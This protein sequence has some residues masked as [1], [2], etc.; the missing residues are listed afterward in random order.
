M[1]T[2]PFR[3]V[4]ILALG[5]LIATGVTIAASAITTILTP[6]AADR[7]DQFLDGLISEDE[8]LD[9][10]GAIS[11][12]QLVQSVATAAT[13]VM[14]IIW[15]YRVA[16]NV[17]SVGRETTWAPIFA[18]FGWVLPPVLVIIPFLMLRE[19]WKA[20]S[21]LPETGPNDWRRTPDLPVI[22]I[23]FLLYGVLQTVLLVVQASAFVGGSLSNDA[24]SLAES[25]ENAGTVSIVSGAGVF[26]AGVAWM[27][28]VRR[29]T[30]RHME[31]TNEA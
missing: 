18:I 4:R 26:L 7:A 19:L 5:V 29:L 16:K 31:L 3:R 15:M 17:R 24:E 1:A 10:Y 21:P 8:F 14:T 2:E 6:A 28:V 22:W 23:W 9:S 27:I 25:I 13:A 20:S 12:A 30:D 11:S